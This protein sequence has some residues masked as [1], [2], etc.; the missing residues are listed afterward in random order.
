MINMTFPNFFFC[1]ALGF[2]S[3]PGHVQYLFLTAIILLHFHFTEMCK[4]NPLKTSNTENDSLPFILTLTYYKQL[5]SSPERRK[6]TWVKFL[7]QN[8]VHLDLLIC[9]IIQCTGWTNY[10]LYNRKNWGCDLLKVMNNH[11]CQ[12]CRR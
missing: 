2:S 8:R 5:S 9:C 4:T 3:I 1:H 12:R 10:Y 7:K 11:Y 6:F